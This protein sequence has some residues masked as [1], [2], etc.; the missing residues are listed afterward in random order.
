M[1]FET[2]KKDYLTLKFNRK[3]TVPVTLLLRA[4]AAVD[5]ALPKKKSPVKK[6]SDQELLKLFRDVDNDPDRPFIQNSINEEPV[7]ELE[8][9][10]DDRRGCPDRVLQTYATRRPADAGQRP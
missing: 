2:R 4:L 5:D 1:E 7:W 6:G 9:G 8:E 3:R 10:A